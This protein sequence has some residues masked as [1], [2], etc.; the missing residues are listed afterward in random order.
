MDCRSPADPA[1]WPASR[2]ALAALLALSNATAVAAAS[3]V[4]G[5]HPDLGSPLIAFV[6]TLDAATPPGQ[7]RRFS[8]LRTAEAALART[9][10]PDVGCSQS[11][12]A[13]RYGAL[14]AGLASARQALGDRRG[15]IDA[16][17]RA[18]DCEPRNARYRIV[19]GGLLLTYAELDAARA[20]A[21]R[22]ARLA[23]RQPGLDELQARLAYLG[24]QWSEAAVR[25]QGIADTLQ[26]ALPPAAADAAAS[27]AD[28]GGDLA[29]FWRLL[30]LLAQ[31]RGG[32]PWEALPGP[33]P[34]LEDRWPVPLWSHAVD[35]LDERG[36][37][38]AI[39]SEEAPRR[40]REM[41]C[42]ALY[43]TAQL[44][45]TTAVP[46]MAVGASPAS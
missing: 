32:L 37:V 44:A 18:V 33:D 42:E 9:P 38:A 12:G 28:G 7:E 22:A 13:A 45:F 11:L 46:R 25:A 29:A 31:R 23:P 8:E 34:E 1:R 41:A 30:A 43:Y 40:R 19:L 4:P 14:H 2:A 24:G 36:I 21:E 17:R 16:W 39:E 15:A 5:V 35:T 27:G 10:G 20:Q 3:S 26:G 6:A